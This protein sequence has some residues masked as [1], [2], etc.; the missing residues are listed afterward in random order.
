MS[1]LKMTKESIDIGI[2]VQDIER[3]AEFYG[4]KLGLPVVREVEI[5][6]EKARQ[7]GCASGRF[8]FKAF[9]AGEVQLK[10]VQTDSKPPAGT[11]KVDAATG[12]RYITFTV[13][14]V[15]KTYNDLK[16][17]GVPIEGEI[18][19]VVPGRFIVFFRDPDG[20]MLEAVGPK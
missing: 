19:E 9:Q 6:A 3:A 5:T 8:A 1:V 16:A 2:V 7:A 15:E 13:E 12:Y 11:G 18:T 20:N 4:G 10:V 17:L 14:S